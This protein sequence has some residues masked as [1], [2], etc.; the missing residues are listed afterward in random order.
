LTDINDLLQETPETR[1]HNDAY[2]AQAPQTAAEIAV[3]DGYNRVLADH[4]LVLGQHPESLLR[5][6]AN[7]VSTTAINIAD[8]DADPHAPER[9]VAYVAALALEFIA[10]SRDN[11]EAARVDAVQKVASKVGAN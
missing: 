8:M 11:G 2:A 1:A 4:I 7:I 5:T 6:V 9:I 3:Y 10:Q